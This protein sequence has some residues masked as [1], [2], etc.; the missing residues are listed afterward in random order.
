MKQS[1]LKI[2]TKACEL[3]ATVLAGRGDV[4]EALMPVGWSLAVFF[5]S[6]MISGSKGTLKAF[7]PTKPVKLKV[8]KR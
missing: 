8:V 2:R 4:E 3:A 7:G 6:Y 5:E 1:S